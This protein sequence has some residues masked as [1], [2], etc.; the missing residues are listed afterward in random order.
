MQK[1]VPWLVTILLVAL[2]A[3]AS[4]QD[5]QPDQDAQAAEN[6]RVARRAFEAGR[7]AF[8]AGDYE[9]ALIRFREAYELSHRSEL[10]YNIAQSLDR[11]R[12]DEET[13]Q[14]LRQYLQEVPSSR[15]RAEVEARIRVL[16]QMVQRDQ[17]Q[18]AQRQQAE[19]LARAERERLERLRQEHERL[20][21][22]SE[23]QAAAQR[24]P[25]HPALALTVAGLA[26]AGG[27]VAVWTGLETLSLHDRYLVSNNQDEI[28]RL[29]G[30]G[31]TYQT[32]TNV[33][34][35]SSA[36]LAAAA[37]IMLFF[38]DWGGEAAPSDGTSTQTSWMPTLQVGS[39]GAS[40]GA[41]GRF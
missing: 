6:D 27:G 16:E 32:A 11:L 30:D 7:Q 8:A 25:L 28:D 20:R 5:A 14:T 23:A 31:M 38:T 41:V 24:P 17:E 2:A 12:R 40:L 4:A 37:F 34:I 9:T 1:L 22:E 35:F 13:L 39:D 26:L 29:H 10:L 36:G 33:L 21:Q 15:S 3:P 18:E 19:E